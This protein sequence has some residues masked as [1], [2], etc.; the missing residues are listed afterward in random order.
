MKM[1]P[2]AE[3][4]DFEEIIQAAEALLSKPE[5]SPEPETSSPHTETSAL[6]AETAPKIGTATDAQETIKQ[7]LRDEYGDKVEVSIS[8]TTLESDES[9]G[10]RLWVV[11]GN[12]EVRRRLFRKK[13]WHFTYFLDAAEGKIRIVR[14]SKM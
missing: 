3:P 4:D 13:K 10:R 8:N 2:T 12:A 6:I 14:S 11:K 5:G 7:K 9:E 1:E